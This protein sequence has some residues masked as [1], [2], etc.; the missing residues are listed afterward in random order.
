[1]HRLSLGRW[2]SSLALDSF[3]NVQTYAD[4][5]VASVRR[6]A[7]PPWL[8]GNADVEYLSNPEL[9]D[10]QIETIAAWAQGDRALGDPETPGTSL[11]NLHE[12]LARVDTTLQMTEP[13]TPPPGDDYRCFLL[14]W[15]QTE[16]TYV[17]GINAVPGNESIVHHIAVFIIPPSFVSTAESW[18]GD[19]GRPGYP[20]FGGPSGNPDILIPTLQLGGWLPGNPGTKFPR[21]IGIEVEPGSMLALQMHYSSPPTGISPD[22]T[23]LEFEITT[24]VE[25][26]GVYAPW[27]NVEWV[28]GNMPI[29][30]GEE[31]VEHKIRDDPRLFFGAFI[32]GLDLEDGFDIHGTLFH[33]HQL[34]QSGHT[35]LYKEDGSETTILNIP[36]WDFN[37]QQEYFLKEPV[38]FRPGDELEI[39]CV[40][41]NS[42]EAQPLVGNERRP[43]KDV[44]WGERT[45]DEMCVVNLLITEALD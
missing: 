30:A 42:A 23:T 11:P 24:S 2:N 5:M 17:R 33:M 9:T 21:G 32:G 31:R 20:C 28:G 29:P 18:K 4:A 8:A 45:E 14:P 41:S 3:E 26:R 38:S 44:N 13:Y 34:G 37:W 36:K 10:E 22:Q 27:L 15:D 7:M 43:A 40:W 1:M 12:G 35:R 39:S 19:D 25:K 6:R 16:T